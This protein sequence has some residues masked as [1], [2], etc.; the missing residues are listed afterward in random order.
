MRVM[1]MGPAAN[2][3]PRPDHAPY[4]KGAMARDLVQMMK[5]LGFDRFSVAGHDRGGRVGYRLALDHADRIKRLAL[6]DISATYT[7]TTSAVSASTPVTVRAR[8]TARRR[9]Q[10]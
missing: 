10:R 6:F 9:P 2:R 4:T 7:V 8:S 3:L 1:V 5:V